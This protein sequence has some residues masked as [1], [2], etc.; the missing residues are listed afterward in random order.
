MINKLKTCR[1]CLTE[2]DSLEELYEFSSE[3]SLDD[4]S[5][6]DFIKIS[7]C[8]H[9]LTTIRIPEDAE[10]EN[11]IC[12]G[13]LTDLK[14]CFVFLKKCQSSDDVYNN[15]GEYPWRESL[16]FTLKIEE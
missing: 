1:C 13:C 3:F 8:F 7:E 14:F 5:G 4:D 12:S 6:D 16:Y 15:T 2:F 11:K 9:S 10:D